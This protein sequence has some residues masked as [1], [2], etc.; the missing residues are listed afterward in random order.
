MK[1]EIRLSDVARNAQD[2][3]KDLGR[4]TKCG[5][6]VLTALQA[7]HLSIEKI[8]YRMFVRRMRAFMKGAD[9]TE[10]ISVF[11]HNVGIVIAAEIAQNIKN[12]TDRRA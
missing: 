10:W 1:K 8:K 4:E 5:S 12:K 2:K 9:L 6:A 3:P 11:W 7:K